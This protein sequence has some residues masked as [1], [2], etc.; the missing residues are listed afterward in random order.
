M[1]PVLII[2]RDDTSE[3]A[4]DFIVRKRTE[5]GNHLGGLLADDRKSIRSVTQLI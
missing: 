5:L 4:V 1:G 3:S 2:A